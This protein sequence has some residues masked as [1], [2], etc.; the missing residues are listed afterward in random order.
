MAG[1][2][3]E[4][5][6]VSGLVGTEC[7]RRAGAFSG[8]AWRRGVLV[9]EDD[10]VLRPFTIDQSE[11]NHLSLN[12]GQHRIDL[13]VDLATLA[14]V[15]H[16]PFRDPRT[17]G[18]SRVGNVGA[19][20]AGCG[21]R[22][23]GRSR[24][25]RGCGRSRGLCAAC[26]CCEIGDHVGSVISG[27]EA[28]KRHLVARHDL[29]RFGQVLVERLSVPDDVSRFHRRRII[30]TGLRSRLAADN[31]G[32]R[33]AE[34]VLAGF[35]RM[36]SLAFPEDQTARGGIARGRHCIGGGRRRIGGRWRRRLPC[37]GARGRGAIRSHVVMSGR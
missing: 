11:L 30:V 3:A 37:R 9:G 29:R 14:D 17:Q 5:N 20:G 22:R 7:D 27:L 15:S 6:E 4:I 28:R 16:A 26:A 35:D 24:L 10:I 34:H 1:H 8:N 32:Q 19:V 2:A 21:L 13:A 12:G 33:R 25:W 23:L 31:S 36:A 18:V